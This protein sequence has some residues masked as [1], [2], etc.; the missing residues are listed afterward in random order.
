MRIMRKDGLLV[1]VASMAI[2]LSVLGSAAQST[3]T[4]D[5]ALVAALVW[6]EY[7]RLDLRA[8]L[9]TVKAELERARERFK[10]YRSPRRRSGNSPFVEIVHAAMV[11]Y[12]RLLMSAAGPEAQ[13]LAVEYVDKVRPC[14]EWEGYHD[15]PEHEAIFAGEYLAANLTGPFKEYLPLLAGHR[16]LCAAEAYDYEKRPKDADRSR[17]AA[18][19]AIQTARRSTALTIRIAAETL[20]ARGRC[21]FPG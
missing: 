21:H 2:G 17:R 1:T 15:C 9:P 6:G 19:A 20:Q 12:E 16:W 7:D 14:Y 3:R 11:R 10:A 13:S 4:P 8:Y 18:D 5:D